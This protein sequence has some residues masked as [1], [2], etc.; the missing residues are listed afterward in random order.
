M[1]GGYSGFFFCI[2][3]ISL[4]TIGAYIIGILIFQTRGGD[5][6]TCMSVKSFPDF[7]FFGFG[8][9]LVILRHLGFQIEPKAAFC[10]SGRIWSENFGVND[11]LPWQIKR[12]E[13]GLNRRMENS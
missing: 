13:K 8:P 3:S 5:L 12:S 10:H 1:A 7:L 9:G 2:V 4:P 6:L 11:Q